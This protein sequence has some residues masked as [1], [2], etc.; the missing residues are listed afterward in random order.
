MQIKLEGSILKV[1]LEQGE[2]VFTESRRVVWIQ[3]DV[4]ITASMRGRIDTPLDSLEETI[5]RTKYVCMGA[6]ASIGFGMQAQGSVIEEILDN[7]KVLIGRKDLFVVAESTIKVEHFV[8]HN[9]DTG[10]KFRKV[11]GFGRVLWEMPGGGHEFNLEE[12]EEFKID[13]A[14]LALYE[15]SIGIEMVRI[16]GVKERVGSTK[17]LTLAKLSGPGKVWLQG[18]AAQ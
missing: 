13:T 18:M 7:E 4:E 9:L 10:I 2:E 6:A 16:R 14:N 8:N 17:E 1:Q 3:G 15:L 12:G 11:Y 5:L